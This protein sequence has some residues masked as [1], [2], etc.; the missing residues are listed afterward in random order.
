MLKAQSTS[1][2][3]NRTQFALMD[4]EDMYIPWKKISQQGLALYN[5]F[6]LFK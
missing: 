2:D 4:T 6:W 3:T 5:M 1:G